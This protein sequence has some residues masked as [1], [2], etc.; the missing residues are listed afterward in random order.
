[1]NTLIKIVFGTL[2]ALFAVVVLSLVMGL[3]TLLLWNW[4]V[5]PIFG[6]IEISF[7]QAVGLNLLSG[8]LI[9]SASSK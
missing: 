6:L 1:M 8:V 9:K 4:L 7:L 2:I 3:P 5:P